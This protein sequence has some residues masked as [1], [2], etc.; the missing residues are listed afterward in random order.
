[1]FTHY[2]TRSYFVMFTNVWLS[3]LPR[4]TCSKSAQSLLLRSVLILSSYQWLGLRNDL[5]LLSGHNLLCISRSTV[6]LHVRPI[7]LLSQECKMKNRHCVASLHAPVTLSCL[8][9]NILW[10]FVYNRP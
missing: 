6:V 8:D 10:A 3:I 2:G 1:M 9:P 4:T 5:F 7:L